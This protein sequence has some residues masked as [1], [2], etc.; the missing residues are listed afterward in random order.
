MLMVGGL[1]LRASM[2]NPRE[3]NRLPLIEGGDVARRP[4]PPDRALIVIRVAAG[5][6]NLLAV[7]EDEKAVFQRS[8]GEH[9]EIGAGAFEGAQIA[10]ALVTVSFMPVQDG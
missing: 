5:K 9:L 6:M 7:A 1:A 8:I 2:K 10:A 3:T 4:V